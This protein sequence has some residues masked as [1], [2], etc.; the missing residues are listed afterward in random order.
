MSVF[1]LDHSYAL[2][3]VTN[4]AEY[5]QL[6]KILGRGK[7]ASRSLTLSQSYQ[8]VRGFSDK[9]GSLTQLSVALMLMR[10]KGETAAEIAGAALAL[11]STVATDWQQLKVDIDWPCYGAKRDQ[12]PYLLLSAKLLAENGY[13]IMLHGDNSV[14]SHRQHIGFFT[15]ALNIANVKTAAEAASALESAG[16]CYVNADRFTP[17]V[18]SFG[19]IHREVGLRSLFQSAIRCINPAN[20]PLS[21]RSYFHGGLDD[22]HLNIARL[23]AIYEPLL[24][25]SRVAVFKGYQG[26]CEFNPRASNLIKVYST[27][28]VTQV[29]LPT[30]LDALIG[31]KANAAELQPAWLTALWQGEVICGV[32]I[33]T[34]LEYVHHDEKTKRTDINELENSFNYSLNTAHSAE[35]QRAYHS[36]ITNVSALLMLLCPSQTLD[37]AKLQATDYWFKRNTNLA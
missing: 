31:T 25:H 13:R 14:L 19:D 7:K 6:V 8:L 34:E 30:Q 5:Q 29:T 20:A 26:E 33:E 22:V 21:L 17:L 11:R 2:N 1:M 3:G 12:L 37:G 23:M 36:A 4:P 16:I 18:S 28:M 35:A 27:K 9:L 32:K 24:N 10:V 15:E